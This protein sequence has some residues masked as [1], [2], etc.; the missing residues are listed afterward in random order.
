MFIALLPLLLVLYKK[1]TDS[2][3]D[4]GKVQANATASSVVTNAGEWYVY[5]FFFIF[6]LSYILIP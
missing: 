6:C 3:I 2:L 5:L 1:V 4:L